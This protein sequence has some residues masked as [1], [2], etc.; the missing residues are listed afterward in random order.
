MADKGATRD[1]LTNAAEL[2]EHFRELVRKGEALRQAT[3]ER[4]ELARAV[5]RQAQ[6][7]HREEL[8]REEAKLD[9]PR[10]R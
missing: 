9:T 2:L 3:R 6:R 5:V 10:P 4:L 7:L 1:E 8:Q